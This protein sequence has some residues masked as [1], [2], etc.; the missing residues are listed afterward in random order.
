MKLTYKN[1]FGQKSSVAT[2]LLPNNTTNSKEIILYLKN[3]VNSGA[4]V[5][6]IFL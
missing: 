5:T 2:Q 3:I 4:K 1:V 6:R